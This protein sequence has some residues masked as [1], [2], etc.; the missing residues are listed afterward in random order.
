SHQEIADRQGVSLE[1]AQRDLA[2]RLNV[3]MNR[4]GTPEDAAE[5]VAFLASERARWL[6]GSQFRVDGGILAQV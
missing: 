6:T 1:E 3:P 4:P 5:L 2:A